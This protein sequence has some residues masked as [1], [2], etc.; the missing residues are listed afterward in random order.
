MKPISDDISIDD[1]IPNNV[2]KS[3]QDII[4]NKPSNIVYNKSLFIPSSLPINNNYDLNKIS[5]QSIQQK[6]SNDPWIFAIIEYLRH[7]NKYLLA[8][9]PK[10]LYRYVLSGRYYLNK[11]NLLMYRYNQRNCIVVPSC[12]TYSVMRWAHDNTHHGY[13]RMIE[14]L[15]GRY[16]WPKMRDDLLRLTASC[17][18]CQSVK[19]GRNNAAK[20][21]YIK[22]FSS[23]NI[24]E[25]I[26]IDICGP[27][28]QTNKGN[29]Y[30]V[31]IIDKFSR[32][33][34]LIPIPNIKTLTVIKAFERWLCLFGPPT[35]VLSDNGS[36]FVSEMFKVYAKSL[37]I[38]NRYSTP[39]YPET[40]GQVER[41]HR[42]IKERL[43]LISIDLVTNF[44]DGDD[45]WDDYIP[46]FWW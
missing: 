1:D 21:G 37:N 42:W 13:H 10:Y 16:W 24:F 8:D 12:L 15:R 30:I 17:H 28:P 23:K 20:S 45:D 29:R 33:C 38:K 43:T 5:N 22:T 14:R 40:N 26:S 44:V 27:L 46:L 4:N 7:N 3:N 39:Y 2:F 35:A 18:A 31:S 34:L 25:L 11:Y 32:F 36:Q 6:Q 19:A 41:L 9:L